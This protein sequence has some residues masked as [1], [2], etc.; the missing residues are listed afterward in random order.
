MV[1]FSLR[2]GAVV[3]SIS[4]KSNATELCGLYLP[5]LGE[6]GLLDFMVL[7]QIFTWEIGVLL[8]KRT[9]HPANFTASLTA[10]LLTRA[11]QQHPI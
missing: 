9:E 4:S 1:S 8:F 6:I 2:F 7:V 11:K 5:A 3:K 10:K